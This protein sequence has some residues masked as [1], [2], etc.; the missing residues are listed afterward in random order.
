MKAGPMNTRITLYRPESAESTGVLMPGIAQWVEDGSMAAERVKLTG[1]S[2]PE[3]SE[4]WADYSALFR[5]RLSRRP[6]TPGW[7]VRERGDGP[8]MQYVITNVIKDRALGMITLQCDRV[9]L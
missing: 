6:I 8:D 2:M 4:Q 9:N 5:I 1:R 3:N 7:R